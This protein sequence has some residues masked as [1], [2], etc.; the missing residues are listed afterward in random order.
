MKPKT[1]QLYSP[2]PRGRLALIEKLLQLPLTKARRQFLNGLANE[3][4][5]WTVAKWKKLL[6]LTRRSRPGLKRGANQR[7][8]T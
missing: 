2:L 5:I 7:K 8:N 3:R 4:S 6:R 1:V